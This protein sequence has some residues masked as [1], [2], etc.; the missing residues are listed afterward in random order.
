MDPNWPSLW[1]SRRADQHVI[2]FQDSL[3]EHD[4]K[5]M[6]WS[7]LVHSYDRQ[8]ILFKIHYCHSSALWVFCSVCGKQH[9]DGLTDSWKTIQ[10][11]RRGGNEQM[12]EKLQR[13]M[14]PKQCETNG[15]KPVGHL[16]TISHCS[17]SLLHSSLLVLSYGNSTSATVFSWSNAIIIAKGKPSL[18]LLYWLLYRGH[19]STQATKP[20]GICGRSSSQLWQWKGF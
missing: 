15:V 10:R 11:Q 19:Q 17:V 5:P 16:K 18:F 8:F 4:L 1:V 7:V 14:L 2:K 12:L 3:P 13:L 6:L 9:D 20:K